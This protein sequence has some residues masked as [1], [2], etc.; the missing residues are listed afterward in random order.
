MRRPQHQATPRYRHHGLLALAVDARGSD[1]T[2]RGPGARRRSVRFRAAGR[3]WRSCTVD[4]RGRGVA[5]PRF[6]PRRWMM[7]PE[8]H[9]LHPGHPR[10]RGRAR[11]FNR[12]TGAFV[13]ACIPEFKDH[14]ILD[15]PDGLLLL[16]RDA[17]TAVRLLHPFTG[18]IVDPPPLKSLLPQ[19]CQLTPKQPWLDGEENNLVYFRRVAAAVSVAQATGIV[20]V[21]LALEHLCRFAHASTAD[22]NWTLTSWSVNVNLSRALPFHGSFYMA[23]CDG[24][25]SISRLDVPL[26]DEGG[27]PAALSRPQCHHRR[28]LLNFQPN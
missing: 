26:L 2:H 27:S 28:Q 15:S 24:I 4:P 14:C 25:G 8:G 11:F 7:L 23:N 16:Q 10:L 6:H 22:R 18:D 13:C 12:D 5:D 19:L 1:G 21:L 3:H 20:T 9:G 17:D